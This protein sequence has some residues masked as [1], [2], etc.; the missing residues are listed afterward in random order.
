MFSCCGFATEFC[1]NVGA[2]ETS[3]NM[4]EVHEAVKKPREEV[5][6]VAEEPRKEEFEL[7]VPEDMPCIDEDII[8]MNDNDDD[9][10]DTTMNM[11]DPRNYNI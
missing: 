3:E 7:Q 2:E 10:E 1:S 11:Y 9:K 6:D 5:H 4:D 8:A